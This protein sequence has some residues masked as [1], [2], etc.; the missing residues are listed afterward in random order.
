MRTAAASS[1]GQPPLEVLF[2]GRK[3]RS[4]R[5]LYRRVQ[6]DTPTE[7]APGVVVRMVE[8]GHIF[9]SASVE[10]TIEEDGRSSVVVF[11]G[12]IGPRGAPLHKIRR[13]SNTPTWSSWNRPTAT[14]TTAR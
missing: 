1:A 4:L 5:P 10:M 2:T 8:A 11:S 3:S 7:V 13:R 12:D 6:Y 14:A 9:G